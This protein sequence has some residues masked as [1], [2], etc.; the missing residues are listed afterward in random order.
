MK[1]EN[2]YNS[3]NK[4]NTKKYR[5]N[6]DKIFGKKKIKKTPAKESVDNM[7]SDPVTGISNALRRFH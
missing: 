2:M 5:E 3:S 6:W 7:Q 4:A 1:G